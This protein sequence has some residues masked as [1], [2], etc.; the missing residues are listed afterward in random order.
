[1]EALGSPSISRA[2]MGGE[3]AFRIQKTSV[4]RWQVQRQYTI[5]RLP[6]SKVFKIIM[7]KER[8]VY[9][10][11]KNLHQSAPCAQNESFLA[12]KLTENGRNK[13]QN[14]DKIQNGRD[15]KFVGWRHKSR[16]STPCN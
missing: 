10:L 15:R 2:P 5:I 1:M 9:V 4:C 14:G 11:S 12:C 7:W 3:N 13:I 8:K 6:V 16:D